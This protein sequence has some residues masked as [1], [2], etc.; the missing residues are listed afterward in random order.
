MN[1]CCGRSHRDS[2]QEHL[3]HLSDCKSARIRDVYD[4]GLSSV[5]VWQY[6]TSVTRVPY[7]EKVRARLYCISNIC[8][9]IILSYLDLFEKISISPYVHN[10][11][12]PEDSGI[13]CSWHQTAAEIPSNRPIGTMRALTFCQ[14]LSVEE[15]L[16]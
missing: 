2:K 14:K 15:S 11:V 10:N 1:Y 6:G 13:T 4:D 9:S 5:P 7:V 8:T 16:G 3:H 12:M